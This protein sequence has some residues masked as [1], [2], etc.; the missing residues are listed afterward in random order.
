MNVIILTGGTSKRFGSDKSSAVLLGKTL[1]ETMVSYLPQ[2]RLIIVGPPTQIDALYVEEEPKHSGPLSAIAAGIRYAED[3]L[4]AIFAT[5][6]PFSPLLLNE[7]ADNLVNDGVL[8]LDEDGFPQPFSGLFRTESLKMAL[9]SYKSFEN[10]SVRGLI[11]K[12]KVDHL[13]VSRPLYLL[14][15]DRPEQL[16]T[17]KKILMGIPS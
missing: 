5:D 6:M 15:I 14:D 7:L 12:M 1:L 8:P 16:E 10:E 4:T 17:A 3:E 13:H 2:C 11:S 9:K